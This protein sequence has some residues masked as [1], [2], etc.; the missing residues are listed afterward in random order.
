MSVSPPAPKAASSSTSNYA[1]GSGHAAKTASGPPKT[2]ACA[3]CPCAATPRT[4]SWTEQA[5]MACEL[6]AWT[7][8][9]GPSSKAHRL[10]PK[11]L[12]LWIFTAAGHL[13]RGGRAAAAPPRHQ[14]ALGGPD[15][16]C[17]H[18]PPR[19]RPQLTSTKPPLRPGKETTR[20]HGPPPIR[21]G[22]QALRHDQPLKAAANRHI[23][24]PTQ[25]HIRSRLTPLRASRCA[26]STVSDGNRCP[27]QG[28]T[29]RAAE[30]ARLAGWSRSSAWSALICPRL[31]RLIWG[32]RASPRFRA[33]RRSPTCRL[34]HVRGAKTARSSVRRP[35]IVGSKRTAMR[36]VGL[37]S[38]LRCPI[39][40]S[41]PSHAQLRRTFSYDRTAARSCARPPNYQQALHSVDDK[42]IQAPRPGDVSGPPARGGWPQADRGIVSC[43]R[44]HI[45]RRR[46]PPL[47]IRLR[48]S[49]RR[50]VPN[51]F[52]V[53]RSRWMATRMR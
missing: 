34:I 49:R 36:H 39:M 3:T 8:M 27:N 26:G 51:D 10:E 43:P 21:R 30:N 52:S 4:R 15:H 24:P 25:D 53:L 16:Q 1:T 38:A 41:S 32:N 35:A 46:G 47:V 17:L 44:W 2:S 19:P 18:P 22:S 14:L 31:E 48:S 28:I 37:R 45:M 5:A 6:L 7:Q 23:R 40:T 12:R 42:L 9:L 11:R 50:T 29:V 33:R 20:A 13:V